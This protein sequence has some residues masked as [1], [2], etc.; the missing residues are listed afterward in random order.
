MDNL[1]EPMERVVRGGENGELVHVT[2]ITVFDV[3]TSDVF[4]D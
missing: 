4:S 3:L 1:V 2:H